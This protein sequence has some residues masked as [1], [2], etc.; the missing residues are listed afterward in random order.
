V[1]VGTVF[2]GINEG[3]YVTVNIATV[4]TGINVC[5]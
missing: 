4:F 1:N 3:D 2:T 5:G